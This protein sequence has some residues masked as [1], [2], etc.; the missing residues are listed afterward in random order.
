MHV[1]T[2]VRLVR[3]LRLALSAVLAVVLGLPVVTLGQ[4]S[5][6]PPGPQPVALGPYVQNVGT[7]NAV[8]CWATLSGEAILTPP[9]KNDTCFREYQ[10][11][12]VMLR[13]LTPG[14]TY[15]Y[16]VPGDTAAAGDC[17]FT[18]VPTGEHPFSFCVIS[19]TQNRDN[20]AH[21]PIVER[22]LADKPDMLFNVGDLVSDGRSF[23]DWEEFFRVQGPL[24][25]S[26]PCYAV[27]GNHE[28]DSSLYFQFFALPGIERYYSFNRGA[29]HFVVLD[30]PGRRMPDDN[31]AVTKADQ[32]RFKERGKRYWQQ[33]MEWFKNDLAGHGDAK[34]IFVFLHYP[35]YSLMASRVAS[36]NELRER[37]G[38]VFQ[39]YRVTAVFS[40]HDHH[41]H[42]EVAGGV[43][44]VD[45]GAGGGSAR[46]IDA[47][48][49]P[50]TIRYAAVESFTRVE[51]GPDRA[52]VRVTDVAGKV[53]D[54]FSLSPRPHST[55]KPE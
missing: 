50:E 23:G 37:L 53:V 18:T 48:I 33:Q 49:R 13:G 6:A 34:Y 26:V 45:S 42:R 30:S 12:S 2:T 7:S 55:T 4:S 20:K 41:Y 21:R 8:I 31:Q 22:L 15:S 16:R 51:I 36:T 3:T 19:D 27:L 10:V 17:T 52:K 5:V 25:R 35:I 47:P 44:F 46:P 28:R 11:H 32:D 24:L 40:G 43:H 38:T 9:A 54:E 14:T 1:D 29:A 39:D